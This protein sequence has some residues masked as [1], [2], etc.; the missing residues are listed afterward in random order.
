MKPPKSSSPFTSLCLLIAYM[1]GRES[2]PSS[3]EGGCNWHKELTLSSLKRFIQEESVE[4]VE[5]IEAL[6]KNNTVEERELAEQQCHLKEELGDLLLQILTATQMASEKGWF[7]LDD[8]CQRLEQK[9]RWRSPHLFEGVKACTKKE[10]EA[11]WQARKKME[12]SSA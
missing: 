11:L 10:I 2:L 6:E 4:V 8:V 5:A 1:R 7:D 3:L 9:L 12:K